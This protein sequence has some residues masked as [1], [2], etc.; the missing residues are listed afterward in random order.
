MLRSACAALALG[1]AHCAI[2]QTPCID[3]FAGVYPCD[4]MDLVSHLTNAQLGGTGGNTVWGWTDPQTGVEYALMGERNGMAV[5]SLEVPEAPVVI[6]FLPTASVNSLWREARV[7]HD[8]LYVVSEASNHGLQVLNLNIL[9]TLEPPFPHLLTPSGTSIVFGKAHNVAT[10]EASNR[11]YVMGTNQANGGLLIFDATNPDAPVL[12]G[13]FGEAGYTHDTQPV[14]YH[15][16]DASWQGK[17]VAFSANA[18]KLALID[19]TDAADA[20]LISSRT[21]AN[22]GYVHQC[23]LTED[24]RYLV[25]GDELDETNSGIPTRTLIWDV[26][27]LE[28]PVLIGTYSATTPAIDHNQ[29][30]LGNLLFQS[31]YR[32]GVRMLSL[33][34]I[35]Q[36]TLDEI[37]FFDLDPASDAATFNGSWGNFPYFP[38]G[39]VIASSME[40]GLFVMRPR[41]LNVMAEA[42]TVCTSGTLDITVEVLDGLKPP[43]TPTIENVPPGV[44]ITGMPS[45]LN[46]PGTFTFT[47]SNLQGVE[48][49]LFWT[50]RLDAPGNTVREPVH[51]TVEP[52]VLRYADFDGDGYGDPGVPVFGCGAMPGF[53]ENALDCDDDREDV[54]PDGVEVCDLVDNDCDGAV[55]EGFLALDFFLDSDGDGFGDGASTI[56]ACTVPP[57][58]AAEPGDCNDLNASVFPGAPPTSSGFDNNCNGLWDT[59]EQNPCPGDFSGN[60]EVS[61]EDLLLFLAAFGCT[62]NCPEDMNLNGLVETGDL[63]DF[64][65]AFGLP[66]PD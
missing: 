10:D 48:G 64:L 41:F 27:D 23:W 7:M 26:A 1:L 37:G 31:N 24:H 13:D 50:L 16:P 44:V 36:G 19:V 6:G 47:V 39:L 17:Q 42:A 45:T 60:G 58:Y 59:G 49:P 28:N 61:V 62:L 40:S 5:V 12:I 20:A 21:Y 55:D 63:L 38:S 32:A 35:A 65:A 11:L 29:Y 56:A 9:R 30:I 2:A 15:G 18:N 22:L 8:R 66:C 54:R 51:F 53:V 4:R 43:F 3:G 25:L 34:G 52:S 57:G 46:G 33:S 14:V